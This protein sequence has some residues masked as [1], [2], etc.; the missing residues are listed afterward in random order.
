VG[1]TG[2]EH[3]LGSI[4]QD[5]EGLA[6]WGTLGALA[7]E[8][9]RDRLERHRR[10]PA[11]ILKAEMRGEWPRSIAVLPLAFRAK[12]AACCAGM[13]RTRVLRRD[14][15]KLLLE[16]AG[17]ISFAIDHIEK[18]EKSGLPRLLRCVHRP[19]Q[20]HAVSTSG[21][22]ATARGARAGSRG[23]RSCWSMWNGSKASTTASAARPATCLL[24]QI[25]ERLRGYAPEPV[26][27][28]RVGVDQFIL[29]IPDVKAGE[30]RRPIH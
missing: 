19:C 27:I 30:R 23:L 10:R 8:K 20:P 11:V 18:S 29:A 14:E 21:S 28:A 7:P 2:R 22:P 13:P 15:M 9:A 4:S 5:H 3:D 17:D 16:L 1:G 12:R 6:G 24:R 26:E 25:G